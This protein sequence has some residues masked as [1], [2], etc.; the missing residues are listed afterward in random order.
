MVV[1]FWVVLSPCCLVGVEDV[2][3]FTIIS[4]FVFYDGGWPICR[5]VVSMKDGGPWVG[6]EVFPSSDEF[7]C[8]YSRL[9]SKRRNC[10]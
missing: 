7:I 5:C 8:W 9:S 2:V 3:D 4:L 6:T 1:G 10:M